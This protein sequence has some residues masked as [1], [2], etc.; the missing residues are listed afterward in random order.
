MRRL[1]GLGPSKAEQIADLKA[2]L[3][4]EIALM[5]IMAF[6][7]PRTYRKA[8]GL[9][10]DTLEFRPGVARLEMQRIQQAN[11]YTQDKPWS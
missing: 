11:A 9:P 3:E 4:T 8:R 1:L 7:H 5:D 6:N 2:K 10:E